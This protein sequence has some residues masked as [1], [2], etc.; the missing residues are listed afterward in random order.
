MSDDA[1]I[2][3][4]VGLLGA[5]GSIR[6][7][8]TGFLPKLAGHLQGLDASLLPPRFL[9]LCSMDFPVVNPAERDGELVARLAAECTW[10]HES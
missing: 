1:S 8:H 3:A 5:W 6:P 4:A 7:F 9:V 2:G 10:L